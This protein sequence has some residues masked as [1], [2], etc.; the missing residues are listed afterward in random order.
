MSGNKGRRSSRLTGKEE[1][2]A[3]R[4]AYMAELALDLSDASDELDG[5]ELEYERRWCFR[6]LG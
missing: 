6:G 5:L 2:D 3:K 1:Q 4:A